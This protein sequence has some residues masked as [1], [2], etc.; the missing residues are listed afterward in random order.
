MGEQDEC[1]HKGST[2][3]SEC[4]DSPSFQLRRQLNIH[5]EHRSQNLVND[6]L[7]RIAKYGHLHELWVLTL[8]PS[9]S[10][11]ERQQLVSFGLKL[12]LGGVLSEFRDHRGGWRASAGRDDQLRSS[13]LWMMGAPRIEHHLCVESCIMGAQPNQC[14]KS[15]DSMVPFRPP[16]PPEPVRRIIIWVT[17]S[18]R[19]GSQGYPVPLA[20]SACPFLPE[21]VGGEVEF[22]SQLDVWVRRPMRDFDSSEV[23]GIHGFVDEDPA[24]AVGLEP[25]RPATRPR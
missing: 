20:E 7:D 15:L 14:R 21:P 24:P 23:L 19:E 18:P 8:V 10:Q 17:G 6:H 11:K 3:S 9:E 1:V 5:P 22:S 2:V 16:P 25:P 4:H 12:L 13:G